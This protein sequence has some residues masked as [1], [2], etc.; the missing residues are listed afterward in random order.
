M[1]RNTAIAVHSSIIIGLLVGVVIWMLTDN[2]VNL[3]LA[4]P[5]MAVSWMG[6]AS[7]QDFL[8]ARRHRRAVPPSAPFVVRNSQGQIV[9]VQSAPGANTDTPKPEPTLRDLIEKV[10]S[11]DLEP[12]ERKAIERKLKELSR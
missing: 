12:D 7:L 8:E 10:R 1:K 2:I 11:Y 6:I 3:L 9:S 4:L 5:A